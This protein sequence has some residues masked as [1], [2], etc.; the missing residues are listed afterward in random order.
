MK[1]RYYRLPLYLR[2]ALY[3][4]WRYFLRLGILDGKNGFIFHFLQAFWYRLVI[5]VRLEELLRQ[6]PADQPPVASPVPSTSGAAP[7]RR[8]AS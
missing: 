1:S 7:R 2:P 6:S 4:G 8:R 5:D 3:F